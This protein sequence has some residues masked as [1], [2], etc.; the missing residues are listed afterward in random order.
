MKKTLSLVLSLLMIITTLTALPFSALAEDD[1]SGTTG[2]ATW[3]L[4]NQL[5]IEGEGPMADYKIDDV[6]PWDEYVDTVK[7]LV[8]K[9]KDGEIGDYALYGMT[10]FKSIRTQADL[11]TRIGKGAFG[12]TAMTEIIISNPNCVI[13]DDALTVP[14]AATIYGFAGSTAEAY[15]KKYN[16]TFVDITNSKCGSNVNAHFDFKTGVLTLSGGPYATGPTSSDKYSYKDFPTLIKKVV[17]EEGITWAYQGAFQG[18]TECTEIVFPESLEKI[19]NYAF[20]GAGKI[21]SVTIPKNVTEIGTKAFGYYSDPETSTQV[22]VEGFTVKTPCDNTNTAAKDYAEANGFNFELTHTSDKG[23]VTKKATPTATG[24]KT[25]KCTAC[26]KVLKTETIAKTAKYAN[27]LTV[28]AK[29]P[30]VKFKSLKKKNQ[31]IALKKWVTVS[32]AQ[33]KVTYKKSSGNK[34]IT[35]SK[36]GKITVKKGLKKG[37]YKVKIKVSAAGN[38]TYKAGSKTVTVTIKVK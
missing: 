26:G 17:F 14:E 4:H 6:K 22:T 35:V 34:K 27:T 23:T 32:K 1:P 29:K 20:L 15:A 8:L 36:A 12:N 3:R 10:N 18:F 38:A 2:N 31:T 21:K 28:K 16:R 7:T 25:Y 11:I 9:T 24:V 5:Y 37:T 30:T 19:G 33:G 13:G